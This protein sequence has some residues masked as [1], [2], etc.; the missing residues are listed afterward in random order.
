MKGASRDRELLRR[1]ARGDRAAFE[2]L[3]DR[4]APMVLMRLRGRCADPDMVADVLQ[5]TFV[6]VWRCAG[7]WREEGDV[8]AWVWSIAG[9]RLIDSFR[10]RAARVTT[11]AVPSVIEPVEAQPSAES[12]A[13]GRRLDDSLSAAIASLSPELRAV[14]RATVLD[15][16][17][18]RETSMLLGIPEG[19]V[20]TRARRA[21]LHLREVLS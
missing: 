7:D 14:L 2:D 17:T 12:E 9:R 20:K 6:S 19:T 5:D 13:L 1:V 11:T 15:E 10:R 21:K 18:V 8:A 3:H 16:L 4:L